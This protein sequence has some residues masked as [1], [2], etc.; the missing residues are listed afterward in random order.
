M[1]LT[2][3]VPSRLVIAGAS[4]L[5]LASL[6]PIAG[7]AQPKTRADIKNLETSANAG[8][9]DA[10]LKLGLAYDLGTV[11]EVDRRRALDWYLQAA[12]AGDPDGQFNAAV[13][14]DAGLVPGADDPRTVF[15]WYTRAATNGQSRAQYNLGLIYAKGDFVEANPA[16]ARYWFEKAA[17]QLPAARERLASLPAARPDVDLSAPEEPTGALVRIDTGLFAEMTWIATPGPEGS[18]FE[19]E[20]LAWSEDLSTWSQPIF[21]GRTVGNG[22]VTALNVDADPFAWRVAAIDPASREARVSAWTQMAPWCGNG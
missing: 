4:I 17:G 10:M 18:F 21:R 6:V 20:I 15:H 3:F 9:F 5:W 1:A 8:S 11:V 7:F 12:N 14:M 22:L 13:M 2:S 19:V 16:V